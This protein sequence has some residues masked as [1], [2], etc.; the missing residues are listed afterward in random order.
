V[1]FL[2]ATKAVLRLI[3][4]RLL[5]GIVLAVMVCFFASSNL[6]S[7]D[8]ISRGLYST[9]SFGRHALYKITSITQECCGLGRDQLV[10]NLQF[11]QFHYLIN[12]ILADILRDPT[13]V[14]AMNKDGNWHI[15]EAVDRRTL[16][17]SA[18]SEA[19]F[20]PAVFTFAALSKIATKPSRLFYI[21]LPNMDEGT[22]LQLWAAMYRFGQ[23]KSYERDGYEL[24][25]RELTLK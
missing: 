13:A 9:I 7:F 1:I 17:R 24:R 23:A 16:R 4:S 10:Y 2:L 19:T 8:P 21:E 20:S 15:I 11:A 3:S 25:V 18:P 22:E 6:R 12:D 14:L 5:R